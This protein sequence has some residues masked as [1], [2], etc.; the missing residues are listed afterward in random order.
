M[1][2]SIPHKPIEDADGREIGVGYRPGFE[3]IGAYYDNE[4]D[5]ERPGVVVFESPDNWHLTSVPFHISSV[6]PLG[7]TPYERVLVFDADEVA[8][9]EVSQAT[10]V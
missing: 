4:E 1:T 5:E 6:V 7:P 2:D 3:C 8:A 10:D 9:E